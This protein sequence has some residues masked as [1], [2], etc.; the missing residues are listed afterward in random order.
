MNT[1][2]AAGIVE[3]ITIV[4]GP[5]ADDASR[6]R[7]NVNN[8]E[9]TVYTRSTKYDAGIIGRVERYLTDAGIYR[10]TAYS[11]DGAFM[12]AQGRRAA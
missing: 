1:I 3:T 12:L 5:D 9:G 10:E 6:I 8:A 11:N 2:T 4:L 7:I